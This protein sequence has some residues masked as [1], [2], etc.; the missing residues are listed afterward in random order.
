[1]N[2]DILNQLQRQVRSNDEVNKLCKQRINDIFDICED[3]SNRNRLLSKDIHPNVYKDIH[4]EIPSCSP[5]AVK[6][7]SIQLNK[8]KILNLNIK[9]NSLKRLIQLAKNRTEKVQKEVSLVKTKISTDDAIE[10]AETKLKRDFATVNSRLTSQLNDIKDFKISQITQHELKL[11]LKHLNTLKELL[12]STLNKELFFHSQ[13]ILPLSKFLTTNIILIN[14]F[15]ENLINLQYQLYKIFNFRLPHLAEL[16]NYLPNPEFFNLIREKELKIIGK[17]EEVEDEP[18]EKPIVDNE[19]IIKLGN[20]I[21]VPLSSKTYNNQRR[22]SL[23]QESRLETPPEVP[24]EVPDTPQK[25]MILIP[26]KILNKP[27]NKL[28]IK[29]FLKFLLVIVK[30]LVNFKVFFVLNQ[31]SDFNVDTF[32]DFDAILHRLFY[33]SIKSNPSV[34]MLSDDNLKLAMEDVY[35][36]LIIDDMSVPSS[37]KDLNVSSLIENQVKFSLN[38]WDVVSKQIERGE[39]F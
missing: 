24:Q 6:A 36:R 22:L 26:H 2:E 35:S 10:L 28:S 1:M 21:L 33:L 9:V 37:L 34:V 20:T 17:E 32:Y 19:K 4:P 3:I 5:A 12:F 23:K 27:F 14:Q 7:L 30:I 29:E 8:L 25:K 13:P 39:E 18:V 31:Q 16:V 15:L 38:E 11:K